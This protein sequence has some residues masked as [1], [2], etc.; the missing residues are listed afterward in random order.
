[1]IMIKKETSDQII[2]SCFFNI[3]DSFFKIFVFLNRMKNHF[4]FNENT[5]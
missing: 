5:T 4:N 3:S 2:L 1:M